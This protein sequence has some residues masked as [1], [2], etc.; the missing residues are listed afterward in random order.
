MDNDRRRRDLFVRLD[1]AAAEVVS[2]RNGCH[3]SLQLVFR[4]PVNMIDDARSLLAFYEGDQS[5]EHATWWLNQ[6]E[7]WLGLGLAEFGRLRAEVE[8]RGRLTPARR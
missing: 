3:E 1:A 6:V 8:S 2:Y 5:S 7:Y 4:V